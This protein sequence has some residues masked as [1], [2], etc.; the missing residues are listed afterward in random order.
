[1]KEVILVYGNSGSGKSTLAKKLCQQRSLAHLDLDTIAWNDSTPPERKSLAESEVLIKEFINSNNGCV[2]EGCYGDLL[3]STLPYA[4]ELIYLDLSIENCI[5][6]AKNRPWEPHKYESKEAQDKNLSMLL[7]WIKGYDHR[8]DSLSKTYHEKV[9][10]QF[11]GP[12]Q[13]IIH[14]SP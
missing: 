2:I 1:M 4:S 14:L 9:F 10:I 8:D 13:R 7:D 3:E 11:E 5:E 6:N 12:K